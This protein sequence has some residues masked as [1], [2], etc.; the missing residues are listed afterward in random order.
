MLAWRFAAAVFWLSSLRVHRAGCQAPRVDSTAP[1]TLTFSSKSGK[2]ELDRTYNDYLGYWQST[3]TFKAGAHSYSC[4][5]AQ[6]FV[7][8]TYQGAGSILHVLP[9]DLAAT[10]L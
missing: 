8:Y 5:A 7:H 10:K 1:S 6:A 3:Y 2:I 4:D 9:E